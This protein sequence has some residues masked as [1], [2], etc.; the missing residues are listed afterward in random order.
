MKLNY[1]IGLGKRFRRYP[2]SGMQGGDRCHHESSSP[3]FFVILNLRD[4]GFR[5][6]WSISIILL[7]GG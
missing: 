3:R 4:W 7:T 6:L 1:F 2:K 5:R